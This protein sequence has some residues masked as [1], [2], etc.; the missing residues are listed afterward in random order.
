MVD[1]KVDFVILGNRAKQVDVE[2]VKGLGT[3]TIIDEQGLFDFIHDK[4]GV[5]TKRGKRELVQM[6]LQEQGDDSED[7]ENE[8][9]QESEE[10]EEETATTTTTTT[11]AKGKGKKATGTAKR[12]LK[13]TETDKPPVKKRE[14]RSTSKKNVE[15]A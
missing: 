5:R 15:A 10:K 11:T 9:L 3:C 1:S 8:P 13:A 6:E 14:L 12:K 2:H 7:K 4:D